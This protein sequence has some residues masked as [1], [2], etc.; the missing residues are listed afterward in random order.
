MSIV[1]YWL[2]REGAAA[3]QEFAS[4]ELLPALKFG[5]ERRREG[6]R[7][8]SLSSELDERVGTSGVASVE[9]GRLPDG[10]VYDYNKAHRGGG[11]GS[12]RR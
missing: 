5:E 9:G 11:P 4:T 7:H 12:G 2:T 3:H 1:V 8:V 6:L 10:H